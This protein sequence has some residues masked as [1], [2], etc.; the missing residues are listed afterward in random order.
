MHQVKTRFVLKNPFYNFQTQNLTHQTLLSI[1][2]FYTMTFGIQQILTFLQQD[3]VTVLTST[4]PIP[5]PLPLSSTMLSLIFYFPLLCFFPY[6]IEK[7]DNEI[8]ETLKKMF[9]ILKICTC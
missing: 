6:N 5:F 3:T 8:F 4:F 2:Y 1:N 7:S 9:K